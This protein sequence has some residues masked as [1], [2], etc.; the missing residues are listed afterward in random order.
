MPTPSPVDPRDIHGGDWELFEQ[1]P[2]FRRY[3]LWI[4]D[5]T[6]IQKTEF[7]ADEAL[8]EQN[9]QS[10]DASQ[11]KRFGD[12]QIVGRIPL[13]ILYGSKSEVA[14]KLKEG[15]RDHLK[16]WLNSE[17]GR[18]WRSFRGRL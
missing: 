12:G 6:Y 5:K 17:Q 8:V 2:D 15:D 7:L 14:A 11:G 1:T 9:R 18:P 13:N 10:F 4:D 3:R 16:W